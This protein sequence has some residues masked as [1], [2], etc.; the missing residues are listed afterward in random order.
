MRILIIPINM[1]E[2]W[3]RFHFALW[4]KG[5]QERTAK[6]K[7]KAIDKLAFYFAA[8]QQKIIIID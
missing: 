7:N 2:P 8:D 1:Q 6:K 3:N 4:Q 5:S